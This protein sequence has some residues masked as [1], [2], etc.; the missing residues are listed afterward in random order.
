M[1]KRLAIVVGNLL[2]AALALK[3]VREYW[4]HGGWCNLFWASFFVLLVT[5][6]IQSVRSVK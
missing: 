5:D 2:I 1:W 3:N 6:Y 4:V